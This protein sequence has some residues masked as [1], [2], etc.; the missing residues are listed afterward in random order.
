MAKPLTDSS[1]NGSKLPVKEVDQLNENQQALDDLCL[2]EVARNT[3]VVT[4]DKK[5]EKMQNLENSNIP[6]TLDVKNHVLSNQLAKPVACLNTAQEPKI[7]EEKI[8]TTSQIG[9]GEKPIDQESATASQEIDLE[10]KLEFE[11]KQRQQN[12]KRDFF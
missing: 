6:T 9:A 4:I 10:T 12:V 1:L 5:E 3:S 2:G 11:G 7:V 8:V